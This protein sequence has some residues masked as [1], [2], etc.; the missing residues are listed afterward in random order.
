MNEKN[1]PSGALCMHRPH[2]LSQKGE[3]RKKLPSFGEKVDSYIEICYHHKLH[4]YSPK[5]GKQMDNLV[6][7]LTINIH[8][9]TAFCKKCKRGPCL[10]PRL[11]VGCIPA[12][13]RIGSEDLI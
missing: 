5:K 6:G 2:F 8:I 12:T 1:E 10:N 13:I 9:V 7:F 11:F 4:Q 3:K